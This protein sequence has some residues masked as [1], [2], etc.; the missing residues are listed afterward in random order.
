MTTTTKRLTLE[1]Y[2]KYDDGTDSCY[3]LVSGELVPMSLGMGQH[4]E[5]ADFINSEFRAEIKRLT[6][7]LV[8]KQMV[9]GIQSPR[10]GRW[11]T[12]RVPD[13]VVIPL[14]Q[15]RSLQNRE[16]VIALNKPPPLLVIEVVSESTKSTDYR[17][18]RAEYSVLEIPEYWIVDPLKGKVTVLI[19]VEGWYETQELVNTDRI[20]SVTFP[21][22]ELTVEQLL[23]DTI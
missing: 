20:E 19:L 5:N 2:F 11:D 3:E 12:V 15:W 10:G 21:S 7:K 4:G 18:K 9:I 16:A 23:R 8:S 6:Q 17:A 14:E 1:D 22:L 13:A